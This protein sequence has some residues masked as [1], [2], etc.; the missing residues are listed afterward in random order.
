M[1][2]IG[3]VMKGGAWWLSF[4]YQWRFP[5]RCAIMFPSLVAM[6]SGSFLESFLSM[7]QSHLDLSD[8]QRALDA[9]WQFTQQTYGLH[10]PSREASSKSSERSARILVLATL[11][12]YRYQYPPKIRQTIY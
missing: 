1:A 7:S 3:A 10:R 12:S 6:V 11:L 5:W 8:Q 4:W 2:K 9:H